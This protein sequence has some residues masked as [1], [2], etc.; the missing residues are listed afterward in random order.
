MEVKEHWG[1]LTPIDDPTNVIKLTDQM[2]TFGRG[3]G[4]FLF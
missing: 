1:T 4:V 2:Y 3:E